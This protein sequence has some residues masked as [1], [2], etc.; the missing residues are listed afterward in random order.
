M[1]TNYEFLTRCG[2]PD[3]TVLQPKRPQYEFQFLFNYSF[4]LEWIRRSP[5][6]ME[7]G[8]GLE[9]RGLIPGR[10]KKIFSCPQRLDRL[11]GT[12]SLLSNG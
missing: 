8:Y 11:W 12:P 10:G 6:G 1:T 7:M 5:V 2:L 3:Y 4:L 9:D